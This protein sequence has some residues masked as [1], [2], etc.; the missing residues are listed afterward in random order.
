M[1]ETSTIIIFIAI[2]LVLLWPKTRPELTTTLLERQ[3]YK[4]IEIVG[5]SWFGCGR[6]DIWQT[7]FIIPA[8]PPK[9]PQELNGVACKG[10]FKGTTV[11]YF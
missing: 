7:K 10:L 9:N 4:N 8:N 3:G 2:I 1:K 6:G 11:R 5:Y